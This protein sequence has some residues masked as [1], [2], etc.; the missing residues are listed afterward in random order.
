[1]RT[2]RRAI[3]LG[4]DPQMQAE[5]RGSDFND[6]CARH[7]G[8]RIWTGKTVFLDLDGTLI[9]T[10]ET[11]TASYRETRRG[12]GSKSHVHTNYRGREYGFEITAF[13]ASAKGFLRLVR[14]LGARAYIT[15]AADDEYVEKVSRL[16]GF[17]E[18]VDGTYGWERMVHLMGK[19]WGVSP[20]DLREAIDEIG[21]TDPLR[22]CI[23]IGNDPDSDIPIYPK[24]LVSM[25]G[26][27]MER[28]FGMGL[29][30][31]SYCL[32][33]GESDFARGFDRIFEED[34]DRHSARFERTDDHPFDKRTNGFARIIRMMPRIG[35]ADESLH[36]GKPHGSDDTN[37]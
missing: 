28:L 12:I 23:M 22:N 20:K 11:A 30:H 19:R 36:S 26:D 5:K 16:S 18:L 3:V 9:K 35:N 7:V 25:I 31:L 34:P 21:E 2:G 17:S 10:E 1:M 8:R 27:D 32:D 14:S 6:I 15:S 4:R 37:Y 29:V 33:A 24:G 13:S